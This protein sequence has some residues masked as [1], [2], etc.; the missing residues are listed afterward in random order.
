M[1]TYKYLKSYDVNG[2]TLAVFTFEH[3]PGKPKMVCAPA[4]L[5]NPPWRNEEVA[6]Q[7]LEVEAPKLPGAPEPSPAELEARALARRL[8]RA[9]ILARTCF[10]RWESAPVDDDG[11]PT[12]STAEAVQEFLE[13]LVRDCYWQ[14]NEYYS[15]IT[16]PTNFMAVTV[17]GVAALAKN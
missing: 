1:A 3:L 10:R 15:W 6:A 14:F 16:T 13:W 8:K 11:K 4:A 12:E 2:E 7:V 9:G 5:G 17:A